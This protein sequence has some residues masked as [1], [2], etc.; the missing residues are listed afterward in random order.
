MS[1]IL[2]W[3]HRCE[4]KTPTD[5]SA[6]EDSCDGSGRYTIY[7]ALTR[8]RCL[9]NNRSLG[10]EYITCEHMCVHMCICVFTL[11]I[12][13]LKRKKNNSCRKER[14]TGKT[15]GGESVQGCLCVSKVRER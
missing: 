12:L 14:E 1:T 11:L 6:K 4:G 2:F 8:A 3:W 7:R 13:F 15:C 5:G 9:A 10:H